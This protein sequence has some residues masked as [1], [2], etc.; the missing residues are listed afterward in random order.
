MKAPTTSNSN[1][2]YTT[3]Y[4]VGNVRRSVFTHVTT[5]E[6][7]HCL[8][9]YIGLLLSVLQRLLEI[10]RRGT[11]WFMKQL[12]HIDQ[13]RH[14]QQTNKVMLFCVPRHIKK[15]SNSNTVN[16]Y[17]NYLGRK[18]NVEFLAQ[19]LIAPLPLLKLCTNQHSA[20]EQWKSH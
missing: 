8:H 7:L 10:P 5:I 20:L 19:L 16:V 12:Q 3:V 6:Q 2:P 11:I 17:W 13:W 18:W 15:F 14:E 4:R 9:S 1:V